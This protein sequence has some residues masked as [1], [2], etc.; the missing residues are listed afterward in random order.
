MNP[1]NLL[2]KFFLSLPIPSLRLLDKIWNLEFLYGLDDRVTFNHNSVEHLTVSS[3]RSPVEGEYL[4]RVRELVAKTPYEPITANRV[5]VFKP[6][7]LVLELTGI[8]WLKQF[9][10]D[11]LAVP[12]FPQGD[13]T[14][15]GESYRPHVSVAQSQVAEE[16]TDDFTKRL[17]LPLTWDPVYLEVHGKQPDGACYWPHPMVMYFKEPA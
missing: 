14:W 8:D 6:N 7:F 9:H 16:F 5:I 12:G 1:N 3:P 4:D 2:P 10:K 13:P 11:L 17:D 15:E